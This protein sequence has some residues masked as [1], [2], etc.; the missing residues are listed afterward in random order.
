LSGCD[1]RSSSAGPRRDP[2]DLPPSVVE[3]TAHAAVGYDRSPGIPGLLAVV[4]VP[5][6]ALLVVAGC[7]A[8][9][10]LAASMWPGHQ[11]VRVAARR[12]PELSDASR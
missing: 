6:G 3:T 4:P 1:F 5:N 7:V 2:R 8:G 11:R 9:L 12:P 10:V